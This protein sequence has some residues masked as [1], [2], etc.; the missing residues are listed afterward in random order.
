MND[1][2][3]RHYTVDRYEGD[4]I[5]REVLD[6]IK[7]GDWVGVNMWISPLRVYA[8]SNNFFVMARWTVRGWMYSVCEK[9]PRRHQYNGIIPGY[10]HCGDDYWLFGAPVWSRFGCNGYDFKNEEAAQA[11]INS[12][13]DASLNDIGSGG[14]LSCISYRRAVPIKFIEI[15][16]GS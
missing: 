5:T 4:Q 14:Q 3:L 13:E 1:K 11:Y 10:Y 7:V 6:S 15:L 12:F 9:T 8:V 16:R 2:R